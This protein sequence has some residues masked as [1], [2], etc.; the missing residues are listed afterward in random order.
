MFTQAVVINTP[1]GGIVSFS[2]LN[3]FDQ[4]TTWAASG[5]F[6]PVCLEYLTWQ[7]FTVRIHSVCIKGLVDHYH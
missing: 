5:D 4:P 3:R 2:V 1:F 6:D 7:A